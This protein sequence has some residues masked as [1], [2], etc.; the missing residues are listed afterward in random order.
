MGWLLIKLVNTK[1]P[2]G[3]SLLAFI[4]GSIDFI[5]DLVLGVLDA[6]GTFLLWV[7]KHMKEPKDS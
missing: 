3:Q 5:T 4:G 6:A 1:L 2:G 7:R